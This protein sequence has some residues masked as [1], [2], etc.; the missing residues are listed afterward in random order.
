M[1]RG[2]LSA[3]VMVGLGI[4]LGGCSGA[5]HAQPVAV[6]GPALSSGDGNVASTTGPGA[7]EALCQAGASTAARTLTSAFHVADSAS[8]V[9]V[10][11]LL[12][13]YGF[14]GNSEVGNIVYNGWI[15][16]S[17]GFLG[18]PQD[19]LPDQVRDECTGY[20]DGPDFRPYELAL[21]C[22]W[23]DKAPLCT[24]PT[25]AP[26]ASSAASCGRQFA[27]FVLDS[28]MPAGGPPP[29]TV[30]AWGC[31]GPYVQI[32]FGPAPGRDQVVLDASVNSAGLF[33]P[34]GTP[35]PT[36][37]CIRLPS[38]SVAALAGQTGWREASC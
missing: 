24:D 32:G 23:D 28:L 4:M 26:S 30:T 35:A 13:G 21:L 15:A 9:K 31:A 20:T 12:S 33:F 18:A 29:W 36:G 27:T 6:A 16:Y 34:V 3:V 37:T 19:V 17:S 38:V 22:R 7:A 11:N 2:R 1:Q 25:V 14:V 10:T 5:G 8:E